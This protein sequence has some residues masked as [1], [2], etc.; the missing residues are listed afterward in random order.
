LKCCMKGDNF[1]YKVVDNGQL[2][3]DNGQLRVFKT[4][5]IEF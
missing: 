4:F 5:K 3:I 2:T 1:V